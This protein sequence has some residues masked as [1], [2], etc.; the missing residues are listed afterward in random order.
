[1]FGDQMFQLSNVHNTLVAVWAGKPTAPRLCKLV[2]AMQALHSQHSDGVYLYNLITA[3]TGM[4]EKDAREL[5]ARQFDSMR[6]KLIAAAVV[7]EHSG[8]I[9]TLSRAVIATVTTIARNPFVLKIFDD[10]ASGAQWLSTRSGV[11]PQTLTSLAR[12]LETNLRNIET[13]ALAP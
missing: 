2:E 5:M 12:D 13:P 3:R 8:V 11:S 1:M 10:R 6:E 9:Y 7:I 4:P